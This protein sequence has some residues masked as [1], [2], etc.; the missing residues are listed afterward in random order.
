MTSSLHQLFNRFTHLV[1]PYLKLKVQFMKVVPL[2]FI[3]CMKASINVFGCSA[4]LSSVDF[5]FLVI[6]SVVV[7]VFLE[8][9]VRM[10]IL[11]FASFT[12]YAGS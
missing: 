5:F 7:L 6:T 1:F 11:S 9:T 10:G 2:H 4:S 12:L 3:A 8:V